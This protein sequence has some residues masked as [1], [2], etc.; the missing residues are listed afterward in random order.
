MKTVFKTNEVAHI[1]AQRS[2]SHGKGGNIFFEDDKIFSFGYH[3]VMAM[4]HRQSLVLMNENNYSQTTAGHKWDCR[5]AIDYTRYTIIEVPEPNPTSKR[6]HAK[7]LAYFEERILHFV[8]KQ[9]R[10]RSY[11]YIPDAKRVVSDAQ[12]YIKHFRSKKLVTARQKRLFFA[13][14]LLVDSKAD[15]ERIKRA[16]ANKEANEKRKFNKALKEWRIGESNYLPRNGGNG[17][18]LRISGD[19]LET[20]LNITIPLTEAKR[21]FD[22]VIKCKKEKREFVANGKQITIFRFYT[23]DYI[24]TNGDLKAGCHSISWKESELLAKSQG[25]L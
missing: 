9:T 23:L 10:A 17:A 1:W 15:L 20:S 16:E 5:Q 21:I 6:L 12:E 14:D 24:R 4:F 3:Y 7:N 19:N 22:I 8:D 11:N 2:Q 13:T 25:W 18:C